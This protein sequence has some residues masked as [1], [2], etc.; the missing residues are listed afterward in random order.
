MMK[1][2]HGEKER[3]SH[4]CGFGLPSRVAGGSRG[5]LRDC[6]CKSCCVRK[7]TKDQRHGLRLRMP[8]ASRPTRYL[9]RLGTYLPKH[10]CTQP[11]KVPVP[12][13]LQ[14]PELLRQQLQVWHLPNYILRIFFCH[15]LLI[16]L[17]TYPLIRKYFSAS[18]LLYTLVLWK[19]VITN[20]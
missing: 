18:A 6:S 15:P 13:T 7:R 10:I 17:I 1:T 2:V 9:A 20:P 3:N 19:S 14:V 11:G 8:P 16:T 5:R 12:P 4:R